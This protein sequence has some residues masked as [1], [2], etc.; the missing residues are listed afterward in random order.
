MN[1][2]SDRSVKPYI[3]AGRVYC[4]NKSNES[5]VCYAD[6][7]T[8]RIRTRALYHDFGISAP[9]NSDS[10][11]TKNRLLVI[12]RYSA[13]WLLPASRRHSPSGR[14]EGGI[15]PL[16]ADAY[17]RKRLRFPPL[18]VQVPPSGRDKGTLRSVS[19]RWS[20]S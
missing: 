10:E 4:C 9:L 11:G 18:P 5:P 15:R 3:Q 12:G 20:K 19:P 13:H 6:K 14:S 16:P 1:A 7:H 17:P 2:D 8:Q